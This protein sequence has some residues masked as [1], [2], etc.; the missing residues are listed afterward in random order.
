MTCDDLGQHILG[1]A[2][3]DFQQGQA[4]GQQV[5]GCVV[6]GGGGI[7]PGGHQTEEGAQ[8]LAHLTTAYAYMLFLRSKGEQ[9]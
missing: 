2:G 7:C 6:G 5:A 3:I 9:Q 8:V 1:Q 4:A